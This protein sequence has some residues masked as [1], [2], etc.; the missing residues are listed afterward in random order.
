M[1]GIP[2][3]P[4]G[5]IA[6]VRLYFFSTF[7]CSGG[8]ISTDWQPRSRATRQVRSR[9]Q[10]SPSALK[11][12]KTTDWRMRPFVTALAWTAASAGAVGSADTRPAAAM[13]DRSR[14]RFIDRSRMFGYLDEREGG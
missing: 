8:T 7:H 4:L 10:R 12:Q 9:S 14:R 13:V 2:G 11:H 3:M 6:Q 1:N 5:A